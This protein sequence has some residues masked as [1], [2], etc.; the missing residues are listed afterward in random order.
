MMVVEFK[1]V[2]FIVDSGAVLHEAKHEI[3]MISNSPKFVPS[4]TEDIKV[5]TSVLVT[6]FLWT[7]KWDKDSRHLQKSK[8]DGWGCISV[9]RVATYHAYQT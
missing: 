2:V 7:V 8:I 3:V 1:I 5:S 6:A 4:I 9:D